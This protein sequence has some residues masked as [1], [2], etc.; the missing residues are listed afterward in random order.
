MNHFGSGGSS[1]I[2]IQRVIKLIH[3][4]N[5]TELKGFSTSASQSIPEAY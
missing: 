1:I 4:P 5:L 3:T 2:N